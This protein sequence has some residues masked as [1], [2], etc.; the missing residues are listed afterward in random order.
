MESHQKA[1]EMFGIV[2]GLF[3]LQMK[4]KR[5]SFGDVK[6]IKSGRVAISFWGRSII[7]TS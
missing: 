3:R 4:V 6:E 2:P 7:P 5:Q 1:P